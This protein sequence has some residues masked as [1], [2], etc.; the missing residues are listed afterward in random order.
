M[1]NKG[2]EI[3]ELLLKKKIYWKPSFCNCN[4]LVIQLLNNVADEEIEKLLC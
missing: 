3:K 1:K 2:K 4:L